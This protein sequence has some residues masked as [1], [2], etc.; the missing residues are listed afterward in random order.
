MGIETI[1][2]VFGLIIIIALYVAVK[3]SKRLK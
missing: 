1:L 3:K 2:F